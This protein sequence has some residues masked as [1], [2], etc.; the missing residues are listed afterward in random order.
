[1]GEHN[2]P[3]VQVLSSYY[4]YVVPTRVTNASRDKLQLQRVLNQYGYN[5]S[6][7]QLDRLFQQQTH[8]YLKLFSNANP[9]IAQDIKD[10]KLHHRLERSVD[11]VP[12]LHGV[13]LEPYTTRY[14][15]HG[16][17]MSNILG[18][19]DK[20][21]DAYYGIEKYFD[22]TLKGVNGRIIGRSSSRI[23]TV[24]ANEFEVIDAKD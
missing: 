9:Q 18:Y 21:G 20:H 1:L 7:T 6:Q 13:I 14:Y 10:L 15:P 4:V 3:F 2:F 5:L 24:G 19:V 22:D 16:A 12:V 8:R 17:F 11:K 23:G